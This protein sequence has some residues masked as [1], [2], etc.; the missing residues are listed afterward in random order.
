MVIRATAWQLLPVPLGENFIQ[1]SLGSRQIACFT[2][3]KFVFSLN[4]GE[5][6]GIDCFVSKGIS[7]WINIIDF[8]IFKGQINASRSLMWLPGNDSIWCVLMAVTRSAEDIHPDRA[9]NPQ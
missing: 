4:Y 7:A 8:F 1:Q 5:G 3:T 9:G 2:Q 6:F